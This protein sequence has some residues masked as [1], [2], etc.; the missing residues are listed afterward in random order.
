MKRR[1]SIT[2]D[3]SDENDCH[4]FEANRKRSVRPATRE[5][6]AKFLLECAKRELNDEKYDKLKKLS[7]GF[8]FGRVSAADLISQSLDLVQGDKY[9]FAGF[10]Y[11]FHKRRKSD[12]SLEN[13]HNADPI[14]MLMVKKQLEGVISKRK[15]LLN[16]LNSNPLGVETL[17]KLRVIFNNNEDILKHVDCFSQNL[18]A[19]LEQREE[20]RETLHK[21][22]KSFDPSSQSGNKAEKLLGDSRLM[23]KVGCSKSTPS[24]P[25]TAEPC[26]VEGTDD[27][28]SNE[29]SELHQ[30]KEER[31][32]I[33]MKRRGSIT[34]DSSDENDCHRFGV[35]R[36]R[37]VRPATRE[38]EAKF[39]LE[40]AKRELNDEK[41]DKLKKLMIGFIFRRVSTADV[42]SQSLD[43]VK[44]DKYLR[45]GF[46][47]FFHKC[48]KIDPSLENQQKMDPIMML[49]VKDEAEELTEK[50][51]ASDLSTRKRFLNALN[52]GPLGAETLRKLGVI[53]RKNEDILNHLDSFSQNPTTYLEQHK[54]SREALHNYEKSFHPSS[55]SRNKAEKLIGDSRLLKK[56][57]RSKG[58]PSS[59]S[60]AESSS[61]EGS[62][63]EESN[64]ISELDPSTYPRISHGYCLLPKAIFIFHLLLFFRFEMDITISSVESA[65]ER[66]KKRLAW[67]EHKA[68]ETREPDPLSARDLRLVG[69]M[70]DDR[71]VELTEILRNNEA[72]MLPVI[73]QKLNQK[74]VKWEE[75]RSEFNKEWRKVVA[76]NYYKA[77]DHSHCCPSYVK[78]K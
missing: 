69:S 41:Y 50:I 37:S 22:R 39:L 18:T 1:G 65:I 8:L 61:V 52:S 55:Q 17:R 77:L 11:F 7:I 56:V 24:S 75:K 12:P 36:K 4:R 31:R 44:G 34:S 2:S 70:R 78:N 30:R 67:F 76:E 73:L 64:A 49:M 16:G 57:G 10:D 59:T 60:S 38:E 5:E 63:D 51:E 3:S 68:M 13:R 53:F 27:E 62:D 47:Y 40:Y 15:L 21:D 42:I 58:T 19:Y 71:V 14:M 23:K 33:A 48:R 29:I 26:S 46:D 35:N 25:S 20:S 43:L 66:A 9:L 74:K 54:K 72:G 28:E 32:T 45:M 6:E